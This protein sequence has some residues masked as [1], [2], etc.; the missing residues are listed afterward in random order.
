MAF[1]GRR[2]CVVGQGELKTVSNLQSLNNFNRFSFMIFMTFINLLFLINGAHAQN[3]SILCIDDLRSNQISFS[4][5]IQARQTEVLTLIT[6]NAEKYSN[7][8]FLKD[9]KNLSRSTDIILIQEAMH[10]SNLQNYFSQN[11]PFDFSFHKSFCTNQDRATGVMNSA[12]FKLSNNQ[13]IV[14]PQGQP[15]TQT[16]KVSGYSQIVVNNQTVHLVNTHALNF[17]L[18]LPFEKQM[19]EIAHFIHQLQGPVIW[20]GDF[21]TW[22]SGRLQYLKQITE[23]LGLKH[24]TP[25][26]DPRRLVLDHI[27]VRGF[28]AGKTEVLLKDSSDHYP[29]RTVLKLN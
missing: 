7:K 20:A 5:E 6:W 8:Q 26:K 25:S 22:N 16:P 18:G 29:L 21:N 13:T 19:D 1:K 28:T 24:L 2:G 12:R 11:L 17:N 14:S 23:N 4:Q 3:H 27:F 15:I 10:D 9:I